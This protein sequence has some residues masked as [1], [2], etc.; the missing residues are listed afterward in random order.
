MMYQ[1]YNNKQK[2]ERGS[3]AEG[4][5]GEEVE[6]FLEEETGKYYYFD[7]ESQQYLYVD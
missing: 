6:V 1:E 5:E 3:S 2:E 7:K 4:Q